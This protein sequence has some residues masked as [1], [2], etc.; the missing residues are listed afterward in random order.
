V[1]VL[2]LRQEIS[3][4]VADV[5]ATIIDG[6]AYARWNPTIRASR[7]ATNGPPGPDFKFEWDLRGFG[8]VRQRLEEFEQDRRVR[9][10]P[11]L[12][13]LRGGHRFTLTDLGGRTRVDHELEMIPVGCYR[14]LGPMLR[15]TG[16]RNLQ[17]TADAL[18]RYLET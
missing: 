9:I 10:V 11:E 13:S 12:P 18:R 1:A 4:P 5:F 6:A 16:G 8:W 14:V 2:R 17:A 15:L 7:A 3:R